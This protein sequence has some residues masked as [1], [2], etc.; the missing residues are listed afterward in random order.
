MYHEQPCVN[1]QVEP[2]RSITK[3]SNLAHLLSLRATFHTC[4]YFLSLR[5]GGNQPIQCLKKRMHLKPAFKN[6]VD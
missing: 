4:I 2:R 5:N 6:P 1:V 3:K